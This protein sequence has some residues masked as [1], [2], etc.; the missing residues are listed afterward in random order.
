M[1]NRPIIRILLFTLAYIAFFAALV[2]VQFPAAGPFSLAVG[3]VA[4][5]GVPEAEGL[6]S[7]EIS[8]TGLKLAFSAKQALI[9]TDAG[10][11]V[12]EAVPVAYRT[13]EK[14]IAV[15]FNDG[16]TLSV[17]GNEDGPTEWLVKTPKAAVSADLRFDLSRGALS[18]PPSADTPVRL[19]LN[20]V[21]YQVTGLRTGRDQNLIS[22]ASRNGVLSPFYVSPV[23]I[24]QAEEPPVYLSLKRIDDETWIRE[25]TDWRDKAWA[26]ASGQR[27]DQ[28]AA[29][30]T[31]ARGN[32]AFDEAEF[33]LYMAE[34]MRRERFDAASALVSSVRSLHTDKISWRSVPFAGRT[35]QA[36]AQF[37]EANL[38][39][40]GRA[41]V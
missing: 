38:A 8:A 40:I 2:I 17:T 33:I 20:N 1:K 6:R 16:S 35:I 13:L 12:H 23:I 15:D 36:M 9:Y 4:L 29:T 22:L 41:H 3:N 37:E 31:D 14:G 24:R 11:T 21:E 25:L 7:I 18:L 39:E 27:F 26:G 10:G 5:R 19:S 34:A 32:P 28:A 30:W